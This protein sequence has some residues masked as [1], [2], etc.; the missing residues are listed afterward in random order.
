MKRKII[1][2][3]IGIGDCVIFHPAFLIRKETVNIS[4]YGFIVTY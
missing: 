1:S 4:V 3:S 2:D